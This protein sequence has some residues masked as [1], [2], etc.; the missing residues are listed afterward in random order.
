MGDL[1]TNNSLEEVLYVAPSILVVEIAARSV[2]CQSGGL[3]DATRYD[4]TWEE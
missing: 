4:G 1:K 2:L 3:Q